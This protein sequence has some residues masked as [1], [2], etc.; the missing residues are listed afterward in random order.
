MNRRIPM[1]N[2]MVD[3]EM[4]DPVAQWAR[5][6]R[7]VPYEAVHVPGGEVIP[8]F[9]GFTHLIVSGSEASTTDPQ[10]WMDR[11]AD[12][13]REAAESGVPI[14]GNCFGHQMIVWSLSGPD[15]TRRAPRPEVGWIEASIVV[16]DPLLAGVPRAWHAFA[17]HLDEVCNLPPPW[18]TLASN[19]ACAHQAIRFGERPIWG[20]QPHPE[21][22]PEE[23]KR[24]LLDA[25][26]FVEES[27]PEFLPRLQGGV[28][29]THTPIRNAR[30]RANHYSVT[31]DH[32]PTHRPGPTLRRVARGDCRCG[33]A[34]HVAISTRDLSAN[35]ARGCTGCPRS[36]SPPPEDAAQAGSLGR[37]RGYAGESR[38]DPDGE[39]H[40]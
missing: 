30:Q 32:R 40:R 35:T 7:H 25:K 22:S 19:D 26:A 37:R 3:R 1:L 27:M 10:P 21:I 15:F 24:L 8:S 20:I 11:A 31:H 28:R 23:G 39:D 5:H 6:F 9:E 4:N 38:V 17:F 2:I 14:L 34:P 33:C 12:L 16:D 36:R 18:R 29:G 13:I